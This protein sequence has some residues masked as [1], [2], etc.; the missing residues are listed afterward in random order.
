MT[1]MQSGRATEG[2][3]GGPSGRQTG[4]CRTRKA[5]RRTAR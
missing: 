1:G 4:H 2:K 3:S 5:G